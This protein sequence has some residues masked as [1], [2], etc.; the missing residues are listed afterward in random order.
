MIEKHIFLG[1]ID[2]DSSDELIK[3]SDYRFALNIHCGITDIGNVINIKGNL[4]LSFDLPSG[5]NKCIGSKYDNK[6]NTVIWFVYNDLSNHCIL[7]YDCSR[8]RIEKVLESSLL[9]F[10]KEY[11][12]TGINIYEGLLF[13][14]DNINP[15]RKI[16]IEKAKMYSSPPD[17]RW[18]FYD[19]SGN[20]TLNKI[21]FISKTPHSFKVGDTIIIVQNEGATFSQYNGFTTILAINSGLVSGYP[22]DITIDE[23]GLGN[24]PPNGGY[25]ALSI[26]CTIP[27]L[28][29]FQN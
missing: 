21:G 19:N 22:Y 25:A 18:E 16:N 2:G 6:T 1:A 11:L 10:N 8:N 23:V 27:Y 26:D 20:F 4:L 9:N 12:I 29:P 5:N 13:W 14:T 28:S 17:D 3:S 24:T 7:E 15:P